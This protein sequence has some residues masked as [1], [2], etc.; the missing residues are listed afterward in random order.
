MS[1]VKSITLYIYIYKIYKIQN[2]Y[3][4]LIIKNL[5]F[6]IYENRNYLVKKMSLAEDAIL[7]AY[8]CYRNISET[9]IDG[10]AIDL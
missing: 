6:I 7:E 9:A 1:Q 3:N 5:A 8:F 4:I 2:I 10:S